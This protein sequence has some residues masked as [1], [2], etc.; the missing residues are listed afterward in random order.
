MGPSYRNVI[1]YVQLV[2]IKRHTNFYANTIRK[3]PQQRA[4]IRNWEKG[5]IAS[6]FKKQQKHKQLQTNNS[7]TGNL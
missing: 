2:L 6:L 1:R 3:I 7:L 5:I 4:I